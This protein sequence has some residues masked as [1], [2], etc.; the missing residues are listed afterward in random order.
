MFTLL[1]ENAHLAGNDYFEKTHSLG[2]TIS[3]DFDWIFLTAPLARG[4]PAADGGAAP[5]GCG[6]ASRGHLSEGKETILNRKARDTH[7]FLIVKS[8]ELGT[9]RGDLLAENTGAEH[10]EL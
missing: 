1:R 9:T 6:Q 7:F 10:C 5:A 8:E 4:L 3:F 2:I